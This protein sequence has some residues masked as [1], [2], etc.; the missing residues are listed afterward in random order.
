MH[1]TIQKARD[2]GTHYYLE[3]LVNSDL[4]PDQ[5]AVETFK[6]GKDVPVLE[7]RDQVLAHILNKY[8]SPPDIPLPIEG[9]EYDI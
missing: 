6:Y 9:N 8:N 2:R 7:I 5:Q 4:P 1:C 3:V